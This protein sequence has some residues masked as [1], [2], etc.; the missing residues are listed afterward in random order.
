MNDIDIEKRLTASLRARLW[1]ASKGKL[2]T[3]PFPTLVGLSFSEFKRYL[4]SMFVM[5]MDWE[6]YGKSWELDHINYVSIWYP[7][8]NEDD[9]R[10]C[11][12]FS[13][14]RPYFKYYNQHRAKVAADNSRHDP[15]EGLPLF[16]GAQ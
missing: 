7:L 10:T 16:A 6:N 3:P 14:L 11:F 12:H 8:D 15:C 2:H 1:T 4:E 9:A 5:L 13:N